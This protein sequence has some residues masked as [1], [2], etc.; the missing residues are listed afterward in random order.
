VFT[1]DSQDAPATVSR[2]LY[3][4]AAVTDAITGYGKT[5]KIGG[6][7]YDVLTTKDTLV[8]HATVTPNKHGEC[9]QPETEQWD[10]GA[11]WDADTKYGCDS[12]D[13][14]SHD[15]A[16]F[17]LAQAVNDRYR[18]RADYVRGKDRTNLSAT[19][20]WLYFEVAS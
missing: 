18:I 5:A 19:A 14:A 2:T 11:G 1:G 4:E 7:T 13:S 15:S 17:N 12:L 8:L 20:P 6:V 10:T 3:S 9:I 16:P